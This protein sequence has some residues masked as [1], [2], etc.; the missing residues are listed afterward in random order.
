MGGGGY[1]DSQHGGGVSLQ[2]KRA[3]TASLREAIGGGGSA[4]LEGAMTAGE[5]ASVAPSLIARARQVLL[6][7]R[8]QEQG[9]GYVGGQQQQQQ[10][11]Q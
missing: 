8:R 9:G 3:A 7:R 6:Q 5:A 1:G 2:H 10:Q 4:K 11:Q